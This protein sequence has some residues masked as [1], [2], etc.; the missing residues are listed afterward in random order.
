[1]D[2][3]KDYLCKDSCYIL[4][5]SLETAINFYKKNGFEVLHTGGMGMGSMRMSYQKFELRPKS[6][7]RRKF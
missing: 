1:M 3:V 2:Y 7:K 4:L 5:D 6:S